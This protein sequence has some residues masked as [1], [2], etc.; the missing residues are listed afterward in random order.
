MSKLNFPKCPICD[1]EITSDATIPSYCKLC[2]MGIEKG[3][4]FCCEACDF[5]FALL[6]R[7]S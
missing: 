3:Q 2:G 7:R 1:Q 4:Q 6:K 5:K